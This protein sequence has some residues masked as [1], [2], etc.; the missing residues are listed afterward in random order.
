MADQPERR[1]ITLSDVITELS[2]EQVRRIIAIFGFTKP[3]TQKAP[4]RKRTA[5]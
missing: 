2:P 4:A 5:A 3:R 1:Q